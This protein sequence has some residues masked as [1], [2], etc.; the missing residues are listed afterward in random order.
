METWA[1]P[2]LINVGFVF[3][4]GACLL[5]DCRLLFWM[6]SVYSWKSNIGLELQKEIPAEA[7]GFSFIQKIQTDSGVH[8]ESSM[9]TAVF[10]WR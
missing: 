6:R 2:N 9:G 1:I 5:N 8:Q 10:A 7:R 4:A 3:N